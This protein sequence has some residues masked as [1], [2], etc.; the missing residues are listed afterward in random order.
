[1]VAWKLECVGG[2]CGYAGFVDSGPEMDSKL[3]RNGFGMAS[4]KIWIKSGS[5]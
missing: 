2:D 5:D 1:M 4:D 3:I